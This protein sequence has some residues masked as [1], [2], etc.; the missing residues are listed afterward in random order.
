MV[1][2]PGSGNMKAVIQRV[3]EASV[4]VAGKT[5]GS[6]EKGLLVLLGVAA[7]DTEEDTALLVR[8]I[9]QLRIFPDTGGRM[10]LSVT[11]IHGSILVVSQFTLFGTWRRGNRPGFTDA[12]SPEK[13]RSFYHAFVS[14]LKE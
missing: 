8:K 7:E 13:G 4:S 5:A 14:A 6:I 1:F 10:N 9:P 3:S 11:D 2:L 12:A